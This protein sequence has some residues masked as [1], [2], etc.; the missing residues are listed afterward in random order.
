MPDR[1]ES[2]DLLISGADLVATLDDQDREI[3]GGWVA[4]KGGLVSAIGGPAQDPPDAAKVLRLRPGKLAST[5]QRR[6]TRCH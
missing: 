5:S 4:L 2:A 3:P 1:A 6:T